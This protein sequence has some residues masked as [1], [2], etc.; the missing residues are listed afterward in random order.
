MNMKQYE[1]FELRFGGEV[2]PDAWA[3]IDLTAT[4]SCAQ[5]SL[6]VK[7]F[8]DGESDGRGVYVVRFLPQYAG[9]YR[10]QVRGAVTAEGEIVCEASSP[11]AHGI[12]RAVGTH[13][14]FADGAPYI[15]FGTT[16]YALIS[17]DDALVEQTLQSLAAAPFN[18]LRLCV[19]PKDYDYNHN[20]PPLYAFACREDGSWDTSR[21]SIAF[22]QRLERILRR[23]AALGIQLDLILFHPYDRWGFAAMPQADNFR[24][25]DYLLRRLSAMPEIWWSLANEYDLCMPKK[26]LADWEALEAFVASCDPYHHLLSCHNCFCFWDFKRKDVT[27]ASI[28]TRALTEI[29]RY[30]REYGKPV[31][32]DECC[33]E[34]DLPHIWG[35]ISGQE[36][37]RRFWRCYVGGGACTHGETFLSP[38]DVLWWAR[39]G[40][41]KGES[42]KRIAFL[43]RVI[44]E[45]PGFLSPLESVWEEAEQQDEAQRPDWIRPFLASLSRMA[46]PDRHM[47][48][49]GEHL[50]AAHCAEEAYLWYYGQQTA[51]EQII[52]LP[53]AH[54]YRVEALVTKFKVALLAGMIIAS[55]VVIWEFWGFIKPALY[56]QEKRKFRLLFVLALLLFLTGVVFCYFAVYSLAVDF[57]LVAGD[58]LA[59]PMLSIDKYVSFLFGFLV[60]FGVAFQLPVVL[61]LTTRVG[62]TTP[63]MLRSKRKYVILAIFV[64]AAILT[65]PDVVSQV[66]LGLPMCGLYEIGILVSRCTKARERA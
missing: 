42:P 39:G 10:Y 28:Q 65:P 9:V 45:L 53:P 37:V 14:A 16:V 59:T 66:A 22:Y 41:L 48:L 24:Y 3:Q 11:E 8:Y 52:K 21:P 34:G 20:E 17:Q 60:P 62:L 18:K 32:I 46:P 15:P 54:R 57:F 6:T 50:W 23:I 31:V 13:F 35:S 55:P 1:T 30:L 29:P 38:D 2:L 33:Y 26:T 64:L 40:V 4:F 47:L 63:D 7:G 61:Y 25:L 43:R 51:R 58:S 12:V 27:H 44:E 56:P 49:C 19:F 36:M 5:E